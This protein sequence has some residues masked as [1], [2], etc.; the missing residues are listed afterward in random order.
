MYAPQAED[1]LSASQRTTGVLLSRSHTLLPLLTSRPLAQ[2]QLLQRHARC[3]CITFVAAAQ[4]VQLTLNASLRI[5]K[6]KQEVRIPEVSW[7]AMAQQERCVS[8]PK[9]TLNK[10]PTECARLVAVRLL[11][12]SFGV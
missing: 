7:H 6:K 3:P 1:H 5:G 4:R 12:L 10:K 11:F 2:R 8:V 9:T